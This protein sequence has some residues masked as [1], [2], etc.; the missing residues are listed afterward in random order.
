LR[1]AS[2][3]CTE[4]K[5]CSCEP[6]QR[7]KI[8][9]RQRAITTGVAM[10]P[11]HGAKQRAEYRQSAIFRAILLSQPDSAVSPEYLSKA[12]EAG[13]LQSI[14]VITDSRSVVPRHGKR[15]G[16]RTLSCGGVHIP[17]GKRSARSGTGR[18]LER[19]LTA[20]VCRH[21]RAAH[22]RREDP[23]YCNHSEN[24]D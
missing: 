3:G 10:R 23:N 6:K 19:T 8:A 22:E 11:N 24:N 14:T 2:T 12:E 13:A 9:R 7:R 4:R 15:E 20:K 16:A 1:N 18:S 17:H 21:Q 5:S